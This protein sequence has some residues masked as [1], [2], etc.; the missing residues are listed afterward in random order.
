MRTLGSMM[1]DAPAHPAELLPLMA[2]VVTAVAQAERARGGPLGLSPHTI[3]VGGDGSVEVMARPEPRPE[4]TSALGSFK[5]TSPERFE[6]VSSPAPAPASGDSYVLGLIFYELLL[7]RSLFNAQFRQVLEGGDAGWVIWHANRRARATPVGQLLEGIPAYVSDTIE[8]M[9]AKSRSGRMTDLA[10]IGHI[11]GGAYESTTIFTV[12]RGPSQTAISA[13]DHAP[14][15]WLAALSRQRL[16]M[17]LWE[18]LTPGDPRPGLE[19]VQGLEQLLCRAEVALGRL[20]AR[21]PFPAPGRRVRTHRLK[22]GGK[23]G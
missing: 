5:Y 16:W 8:A 17:L 22:P 10:A 14:R 2:R 23:V 15:R 20:A 4:Q 9:M 12:M 7:G 3:L 13:R 11:L 19:S 6:S 1:G 21:V 18:R